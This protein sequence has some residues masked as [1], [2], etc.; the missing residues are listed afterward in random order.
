MKT[1]LGISCSLMCGAL[2]FF[3]L[4]G[5]Y[6]SL[7]LM[8]G[9]VLL[10]EQEV[11]VK[12]TAM[13]VVAICICFSLIGGCVN[14]ITYMLSALIDLFENAPN[15]L[16]QTMRVFNGFSSFI[17][18][19]KNIFMILLGVFALLGKEIKIPVLDDLAKKQFP[20]E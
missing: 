16:Y 2:Y 3:G 20:E 10:C 19:V 5:G 13:K 4:F 1:K 18:A 9:Y 7:V 8:A 11:R 6:V 15:G 14:V 17:S 12:R